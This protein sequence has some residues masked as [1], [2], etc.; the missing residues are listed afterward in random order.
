MGAVVNVPLNDDLAARIVY[1]Y[2]EADGY[3]YNAALDRDMQS[4]RTHL[5]RGK[6]KYEGDGFDVTLG[7]DYTKYD[8]NGLDA[9]RQVASSLPP[10][11][12]P[13]PGTGHVREG[14]GRPAIDRRS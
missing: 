13:T 8:D 4:N 5:I 14:S 9:R 1:N 10:H 3:G 12:L 7:G 2:S 6:L 11:T